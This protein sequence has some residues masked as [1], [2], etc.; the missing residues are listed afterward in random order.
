MARTRRIGDGRTRVGHQEVRAV[1]GEP[2]PVAVPA[3]RL[4]DARDHAHD[5]AAGNECISFQLGVDL[6]KVRVRI[7]DAV[8]P[9]FFSQVGDAGV[10]RVSAV[11]E[12]GFVPGAPGTPDIPGT[13]GTPGSEPGPCGLCVIGGARLQMSGNLKVT[14]TGGRIQGDQLTA[15]M[16]D[17]NLDIIPVPLGWYSSNGSNWGRNYKPGDQGYA[18]ARSR[19]SARCDVVMESRMP[20]EI[21]SQGS[22]RLC[23][24]GFVR[25]NGGRQRSCRWWE[26]I[27][28][29]HRRLG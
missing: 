10:I 5:A 13:P 4:G 19:S 1:G 18:S 11:A 15:N 28:V 26:W 25:S 23:H 8:Q 2:Q 3:E 14:V 12:A 22:D 7:P 20:G 17:G 29:F 21:K 27:T 9:Q 24:S 6:V 16:Q